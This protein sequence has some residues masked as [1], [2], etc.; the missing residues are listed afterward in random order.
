MSNKAF[1]SVNN[2]FINN[3]LDPSELQKAFAKFEHSGTGFVKYSNLANLFESLGLDAPKEEVDQLVS[4]FAQQH[5][6][7][8]IEFPEF[9]KI[10]ENLKEEPDILVEVDL[11]EHWKS[12]LRDVFSVF[13]NGRKGCIEKQDFIFATKCLKMEFNDEELLEIFEF[14]GQC[15]L[16]FTFTFK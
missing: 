8:L 14:E 7:K 5:E 4:E 3:F 13:D 9:C 6:G 2:S 1:K 11:P 12:D 10:L 16:L 15:H